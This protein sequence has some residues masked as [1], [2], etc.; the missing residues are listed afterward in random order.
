MIPIGFRGKIKCMENNLFPHPKIKHAM[1]HYILLLLAL[2]AGIPSPT[3]QSPQPMNEIAAAISQAFEGTNLRGRR[4]DYSISITDGKLT[5]F[6]NYRDSIGTIIKKVLRAYTDHLVPSEKYRSTVYFDEHTAKAYATFFQPPNYKG[7]FPNFDN[8]LPE[9]SDGFKQWKQTIYRDLYQH[10]KALDTVLLSDWYKEVSWV[11]GPTGTATPVTNTPFHCYLNS[12]KLI[13]WSPGVYVARP[14]TIMVHIQL[15]RAAAL[16]GTAPSEAGNDIRFTYVVPVQYK[17]KWVQWE[18]DGYKVSG[19]T[20][21]SFIFNPVTLRM[22]SPLIHSGTIDEANALI[23][24]LSKQPWKP[25]DVYWKA[26]PYATRSYFAL[27]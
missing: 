27:D 7:L 10:R 8:L 4:F 12:T 19:R 3:A 6:P 2:V 9:P 15:D 5:I 16:S 13:T 1:Y 11:I 14:A 26:T 20:I 23:A 18:K 22:E 21:V 24:W 25:T 17:G